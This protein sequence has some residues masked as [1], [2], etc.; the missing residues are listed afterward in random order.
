MHY[1]GV[2]GSLGEGKVHKLKKKNSIHLVLHC[3]CECLSEYMSVH[4]L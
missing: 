1:Y 4:D 3:M 2:K